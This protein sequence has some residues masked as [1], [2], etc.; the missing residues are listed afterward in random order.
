MKVR[1]FGVK[2]TSVSASVI[3]DTLNLPLETLKPA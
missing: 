3:A 1:H 2:M